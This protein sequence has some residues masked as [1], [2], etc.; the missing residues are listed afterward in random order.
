MMVQTKNGTPDLLLIKDQKISFVE[1]KFNYE[2]VKPSTV[3]FYLK[4]GGKWPISIIRIIMKNNIDKANKGM[5]PTDYS[6]RS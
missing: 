6:P 1:V 2:T 4:H 3:Q 5:E